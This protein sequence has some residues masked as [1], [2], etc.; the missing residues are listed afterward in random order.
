[1]DVINIPIRFPIL[2]WVNVMNWAIAIIGYAR[3]DIVAMLAINLFHQ[4]FGKRWQA[5][6]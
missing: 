1:M 4:A 5:W 6:T 3:I 2:G